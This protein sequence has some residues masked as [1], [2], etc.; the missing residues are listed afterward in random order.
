MKIIHVVGSHSGFFRISP[1]FRALRA[2]G[3][4][5]QVIVY[6][7]HREELVPRGHAPRGAR[8]AGTGPRPGRIDRKLG[9]PD[10]AVTDRTRGD[11]AAR[12]PRL[13]LRGGRRRRR[14]GGR[15]RRAQERR[16]AGSPGGGAALRKQ[17]RRPGDQPAAHGPSRRCSVR[18][19]R[20]DPR[21]PD[22]RGH[23]APRAFTSSA[24]RPPIRS[25]ACGAGPRLSTCRRSWARRKAPTW[26]PA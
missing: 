22:H 1:V 12:G 6:A 7:G 3:A 24:T 2:A 4:D 9:R 25:H 5:H 23:R 8:V 17:P 18:G 11:R 10:G 13:D 20:R 15:T 26:S 19:G 16:A 21:T 14:A